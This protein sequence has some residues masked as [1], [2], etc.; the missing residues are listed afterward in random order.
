MTALRAFFLHHR[1]V[2]ALLIAL[3]LAM[4]ALVPAGFMLG[5]DSR[6]LTV[7]ICADALG[8]QVTQKIVLPSSHSGED[9]A[10]SDSPCH[11]TALGHAMLGGADPL[12]LAVALAF[13][14]A[15]GFAPVLAP[16]PRR[17]AF[18]RPPLRGPPALS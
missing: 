12:L 7:Q 15:L 4:K 10:K 14:L 3:T 2:A 18:L 6:V 5:S 9:K 13:V 11:F 1:R 16:A 17:I 8:Q